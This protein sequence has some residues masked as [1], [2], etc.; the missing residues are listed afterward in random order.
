MISQ[1][2]MKKAVGQVAWDL[3]VQYQYPLKV[4]ARQLNRTQEQ[5]QEM[6]LAVLKPSPARQAH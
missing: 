4:V 5:V 1:A 6:L 3:V 2:E